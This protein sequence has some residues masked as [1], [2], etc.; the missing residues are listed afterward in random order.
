MSVTS[1]YLFCKRIFDK[2][3]KTLTFYHLAPKDLNLDETGLVSP[4]YALSQMKDTE[5][6]EKMTDKYRDRL[7]GAWNIYPGRDPASLTHQEILSGLKKVR[8]STGGKYIYFFRYA[9][10]ADLGANM[11]QVV[12]HKDIYRIDLD[13]PE[14]K[15]FIKAIDW[16]RIGSVPT[17]KRLSKQYYSEVTPEEY[18]AQYDDSKTPLFASLNHIALATKT[19]AIPRHLLEKFKA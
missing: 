13:D 6:F 9:P 14:T 7:T 12:R 17:G 19:G 10:T 15:E 1:R 11:A 3:A 16:G 2:T 5:L 18:F 4:E 8:G